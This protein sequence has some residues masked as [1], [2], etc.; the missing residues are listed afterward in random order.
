MNCPITDPVT[1]VWS[2]AQV[3]DHLTRECARAAKLD[4]SVSVG[5]V[6]IDDFSVISES[7]SVAGRH[8][9]LR[10]AA[11][12]LCRA[13]RKTDAVGRYAGEEFLI[14]LDPTSR[15]QVT[16]ADPALIMERVR[17]AIAAKPF[18][19]PKGAIGMTASIGVA[20]AAP[21]GEPGTLIA[22]A[23]Q[24]LYRAKSEGCNCVRRAPSVRT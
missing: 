12:R 16:S 19:T 5:L 10:D 4:L 20:T 18:Y 15:G 23:V 14:V 17:Q 22:H 1:G 21:S 11:E 6:D 8:A 24:A 13:V 2:S 3:I 9:L 7:L